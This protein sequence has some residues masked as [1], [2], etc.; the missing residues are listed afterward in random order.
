M[1]IFVRRPFVGMWFEF[2][3]KIVAG[4]HLNFASGFAQS[5]LLGT[6]MW[7]KFVFRLLSQLELYHRSSRNQNSSFVRV[8][9]R[10]ISKPI[11]R[12]F[13]SIF[14]NL[15]LWPILPMHKHVLYL[16]LLHAFPTFSRKFFVC[17]IMESKFFQTSPD[18]LISMVLRKGTV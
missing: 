2:C 11:V 4:S 8:S 17:P 10:P 5:I 14:S 9:S 16:L 1:G 15:C 6:F 12:F 3:V 13:Y 7:L 18:S